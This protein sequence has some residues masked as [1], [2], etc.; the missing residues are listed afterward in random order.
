MG[1]ISP[2]LRCNEEKHIACSIMGLRSFA[3][4]CVFLPHEDRNV[5]SKTEN[6]SHNQVQG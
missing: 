5:E 1:S 3:I 4:C 6:I 2:G